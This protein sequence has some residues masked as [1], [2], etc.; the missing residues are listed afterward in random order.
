MQTYALYKNILTKA[1]CGLCAVAWL[2]CEKVVS[3]D[4]NQ[5]APQTVIEG[6]INDQPGPYVVHLTKTGSYFAP[7]LTF[8]SISGARVTITDDAG[9]RDTLRERMPGVYT[10]SSD[11]I[12]V[13][14][15][16]YTLNV[17]AEG[18]TYHADSR[19]PAKVTIDSMYTVQVHTLGEKNG[20]DLYVVF[21]DPPSM[22]NY[23]RIDVYYHNNIFLDTLTT[24]RYRLYNDRLTDGTKTS[25]RVGVGRRAKIGDTI[26]VDLLSIDKPTYEY[27]RMV[28]DALA[29]SRSPT[30]LSPANPNSNIDAGA[31]GYFT[32]YTI[33]RKNYILQ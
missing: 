10:S 20:V 16:I 2:S 24:R 22:G 15:R 32:A 6:I 8:P 29:T 9:M 13:P 25:F 19:M 4:L 23:Y 5:T 14:G 18:K 11:W 17:D 1:L 30:A 3:V 26:T 27:F 12:G 7:S 21:S 33:D 28:N 31:L